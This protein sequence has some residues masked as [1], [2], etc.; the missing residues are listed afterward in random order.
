MQNRALSVLAKPAISA[1][2]FERCVAGL[3]VNL[4]NS[5]NFKLPINGMLAITCKEQPR[6]N[7]FLAVGALVKVPCFGQS[8]AKFLFVSLHGPALQILTN[9]PLLFCSAA[10]TFFTR[11]AIFA[12]FFPLRLLVFESDCA[13]INDVNALIVTF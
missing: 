9:D 12:P 1:S 11:S 3:E 6:A 4:K 8:R 10:R 2:Y 7:N 13:Y 5:R